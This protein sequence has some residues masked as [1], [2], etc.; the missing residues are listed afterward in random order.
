VIFDTNIL[1]YVDRGNHSAKK[2]IEESLHRAISAVT[3][4]EYVPFCRNKNELAIF[5][6]LLTSLQFKIYDIDTE[7]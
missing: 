4:M 7:I 3:Y 5:E 6:K 2:L 1:I